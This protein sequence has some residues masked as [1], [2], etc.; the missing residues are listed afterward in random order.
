MQEQNP[1][2]WTKAVEARQAL[3]EQYADN[4][5][6]TLIDIGYPP[7]T[8]MDEDQVVLRIHVTEQWFAAEESH[9]VQ[10]AVDGI[11]V[12]VIGEDE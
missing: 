4:P 1:E 7:E 3:I 10:P 11:P 8:C 2:F 6:V 12:C 9:S 5:D